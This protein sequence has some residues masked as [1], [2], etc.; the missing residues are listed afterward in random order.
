[1]KRVLSFLLFLTLIISSEIMGQ[2]P[3]FGGGFTE[4]EAG[5]GI[6]EALAQG[7][8]RAVSNLNRTD[9]FFGNQIYKM[10][11]PTD[12]QRVERTMRQL[13]LGSQVDRAILQINRG[14][15]DA[16]AFAAPIFTEAIRQ[17]TLQDAVGIIRGSNH[18]ATNYF[19]ERTIAKLVEAFRPSVQNSLNKVGATRYY[20]ELISSY[21]RFPT[22]RN[23]INPDLTEYVVEKAVDALFQQIA[24]EEAE[25]R[26]N[27]V[28]RTTEMMQKV[29]GIR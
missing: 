18:A 26:V 1:M 3:G 8:G 17:M 2:I 16:V 22:T 25:I 9:G 6:K 27:P 23:K 4:A 19:K 10:L 5:Q 28:K 15:E 12:A 11:L 24:Q 13:G 21:N 29:F 14:A 7:L 20:G